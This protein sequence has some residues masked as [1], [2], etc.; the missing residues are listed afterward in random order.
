[1][2][3]TDRIR[4]SAREL[5]E[6][7]LTRE[8]RIM[9][10]CGTHTTEFFRT[11]VKDMF[12]ANLYLIDGP[13]CPVCVTPNEYLDTAIEM[14]KRYNPVITTFGDMIRVPSSYSSLGREKSSGMAVEV[15][16]SPIDAVDMAKKN[17][18]REV[19]FLS[20]GFE[21]TAPAEA[22]A[23]REA[24]KQNIKNFTILPGNKLAVPA[25][26]ALLDSREVR[27]DGF[28]LPGHVSAIIGVKA[29][30]FIAETY[31]RPGVVA[32]FE[33]HDLI[34]GT[35]MLMKLV[36]NGSA[37]ILNEYTR[38]VKDAGNER[39][40]EIMY[41]VFEPAE[42]AWRGLGVIPASGLEIRDEYADFDASRKFP[43][44]PPPPK[45]HRGCRCGELLCGIIIPTECPLFGK[46]CSPEMPVGPCMV[47]SEG[48]CSA[49]YKYGRS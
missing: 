43:V 46:A 23:V 31:H 25:V 37:E 24:K 14:G 7:S 18:D 1:M 17:P 9:E 3:S 27:I 44:S 49:Y 35:L 6:Y 41:D 15:V 16:Y 30:S 45:E 28:I 4:Q 32:G 36:E 13:G 39:A 34:S 33:N 19:I 2:T 48:P 5:Q 20:I 47:S 42:S 29:W 12:P 8:I 22:I 10:V 26:K 11:G 40:R 38:V 21:T